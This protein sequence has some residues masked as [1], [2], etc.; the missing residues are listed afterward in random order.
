MTDACFISCSN[1]VE[2]TNLELCPNVLLSVAFENIREASLC[3]TCSCTYIV[4][5]RFEGDK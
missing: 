1:T 3:K 5:M 2:V 4:K